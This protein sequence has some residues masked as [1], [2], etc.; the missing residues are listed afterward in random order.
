[1]Y[2]AKTERKKRHEF[3]HTLVMYALI[4]HNGMGGTKLSYLHVFFLIQI[5]S[6]KRFKWYTD[7]NRKTKVTWIIKLVAVAATK[8]L[9][10]VV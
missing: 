1:V 5:L 6:H 8:M 10:A 2:F 4:E 3:I 9:R 7:I